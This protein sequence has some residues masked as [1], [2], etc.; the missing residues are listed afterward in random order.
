MPKHVRYQSQYACALICPG[1]SS[2]FGDPRDERA[3]VRNG[4]RRRAMMCVA[5][6]HEREIVT[7]HKL[8]LGR[9]ARWR[10]MVRD[11]ARFKAILCDVSYTHITM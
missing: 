9:G 11:G 2:R 8:R 6:D 5:G 7:L 1:Q 4:V 10:A 3:M